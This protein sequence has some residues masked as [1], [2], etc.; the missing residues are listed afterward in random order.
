MLISLINSFILCVIHIF[1]CI[2]L[3]IIN[4]FII[5]YFVKI[6]YFNS[7]MKYKYFERCS[8]FY[9][10]QDKKIEYHE[11]KG[12]GKNGPPGI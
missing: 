4:F 3:I 1:T 6:Y 7:Y 12:G 9:D 10:F 5:K 11:R 2:K 8:I